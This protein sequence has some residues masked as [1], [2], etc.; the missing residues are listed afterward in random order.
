MLCC[1]LRCSKVYDDGSF[2]NLGYSQDVFDTHSAPNRKV[3]RGPPFWIPGCMLQ[4][5]PRIV[6]D[7]DGS[8][9]DVPADYV[10]MCLSSARGGG[11]VLETPTLCIRVFPP[12]CPY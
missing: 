5:K 9:S 3:T 4:Q 1:S 6:W 7:E 10:Q 2:Q 11:L 8:Q 12:P